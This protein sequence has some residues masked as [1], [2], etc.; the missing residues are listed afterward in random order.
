MAVNPP[1]KPRRCVFGFLPYNIHERAPR[2]EREQSGN[3]PV[4]SGTRVSIQDT[5]CARRA[6]PN[7]ACRRALST[8]GPLG[9]EPGSPPNG[10]WVI[11]SVAIHLG[12]RRTCQRKKCC[13][14]SF[15]PMLQIFVSS[16]KLH[17]AIVYVGS[18]SVSVG[19]RRPARTV[20]RSV[21]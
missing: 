9:D 4:H 16:L 15:K 14:P 8:H 5:G 11:L 13:P 1:W 17:C 19:E 10:N 12:R 7:A 2:A 6:V 3:P 20:L 18:S 21:C